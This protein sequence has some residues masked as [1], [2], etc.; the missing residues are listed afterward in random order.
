MQKDPVISV[1]DVRFSW[2]GNAPTFHIPEFTC[3]AGEKLFLKGAS[4]SGK[5]TFLGLVAGIQSALS[6]QIHVLGAPFHSQK[7]VERDRVRADGIGIIFQ[8]FNLIPYLSLEENVLLTCQFSKTRRE[9]VG[10]EEN[11][12]R[13]KARDL[14]IR[15]GLQD[16][17]TAGRKV[18]ALSVGQQ[19]RVAAARA[20]IGRPAMIIADEP[21]S[22]LD[23]GSRDAF[24]ETLLS[25]A[26]EASVL[27]V[28]HD[29]SLAPH[30]GRTVEMTDIANWQE[31]AA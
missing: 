1:R 8:Q 5:S 10:A 3:A 31:V 25:E 13:D 16:E 12:R 6:G 27:F 14:L 15:L 26:G 28:S 21:T 30:F 24:I 11:T 29:Q 7:P 22:A 18:A 2:G 4:G 19:Q 20:L 17:M 23:S 9:T